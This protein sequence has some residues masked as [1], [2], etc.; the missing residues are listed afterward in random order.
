VRSTSVLSVQRLSSLILG[1]LI[2]APWVDPLDMVLV[3]HLREITVFADRPHF[4]GR[5][6]IALTSFYSLTHSESFPTQKFRVH[7]SPIFSPL[8]LQRKLHPNSSRLIW[9]AHLNVDSSAPPPVR[10]LPAWYTDCR[11]AGGMNA[12]SWR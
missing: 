7:C 1:S 12:Y 3:G 6:C 4:S 11:I 5:T 9:W 8:C 10:S 2:Q